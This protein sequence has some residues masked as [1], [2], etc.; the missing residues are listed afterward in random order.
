MRTPMGVCGN[1]RRTRAIVLRRGSPAF[2]DQL[3]DLRLRPPA[4]CAAGLSGGIPI[5]EAVRPWRSGV[6]ASV[7]ESTCRRTVGL[8]REGPLDPSARK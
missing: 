5:E 3:T 7:A 4:T 6:V 8:L 2:R 1:G